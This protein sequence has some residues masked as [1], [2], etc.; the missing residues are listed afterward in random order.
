MLKPVY[1]NESYNYSRVSI[2][3]SKTIVS[4]KNMVNNK[5]PKKPIKNK[6]SNINTGSMMVSKMMSNMG[7][8]MMSEMMNN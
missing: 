1:N 5:E 6:N 7:S 4:D 3:H 2:K 8:Q